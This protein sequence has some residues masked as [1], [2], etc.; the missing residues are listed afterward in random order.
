M[1]NGGLSCNSHWQRHLTSTLLSTILQDFPSIGSHNPFDV[2]L[3]N[4]LK[5]S[6]CFFNYKCDYKLREC[7]LAHLSSFEN[8]TFSIN[9]FL[10]TAKN[11]FIETK[12]MLLI[13]DECK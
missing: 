5:Y 11:E 3:S 2:T 13:S 8:F 6:H 10:I 7:H 9:P 4:F 1:F 12:V